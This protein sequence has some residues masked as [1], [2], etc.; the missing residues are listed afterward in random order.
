MSG[1]GTAVNGI[2]CK[3]PEIEPTSMK[4]LKMKRTKLKPCNTLGFLTSIVSTIHH[5]D[6]L[7]LKI[8]KEY[9]ADYNVESVSCCY[10]IVTRVEGD[11]SKVLISSECVKFES[12]DKLSKEIQNIFVECSS[13]GKIVYT[14]AHA[15]ISKTEKLIKRFKKLK[16]QNRKYYKVMMLGLNSMSHTNLKRG[17]SKSFKFLEGREEWIEMKGYTRVSFKKLKWRYEFL[18]FHLQ[19]SN[20]SFPNLFTILTG[21]NPDESHNNCDPRSNDFLDGC[22]FIWKEFQNAGYV[23]TYA[24]DQLNL[25]SFNARHKG[26]KQQPTDHYFRPFVV[27]AEHGLEVRKKDNLA[28][29]LGSSLYI[30]HIFVY[31]L[32]LVSIHEADPYFGFFYINSLSDKQ[33]I[34]SPIMDTRISES[35]LE[36]MELLE[37]N[38]TIMI[39]FGNSGT[40]FEEDLVSED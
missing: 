23:T 25:T 29:C 5:K 28:F 30:D 8:H 12:E 9:F 32:K 24:E 4:I 1:E 14:N 16:N 18:K 3:V 21:Q 33:L 13:E 40:R 34:A 15:V 35:F 26:F 37:S 20:E 22:N 38:D 7:F 2:H 36:P 19:L 27:A 17:M 31:A 11:D 6:P 10:R 39:Y